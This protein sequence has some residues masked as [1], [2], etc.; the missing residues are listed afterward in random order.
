MR[1]TRTA[2]GALIVALFLT[3]GAS[4]A[5]AQYDP[6]EGPLD[7]SG[8]ATPGGSINISG[9]CYAPNADIEISVGGTVVKTVKADA[10]GRFSTSVTIPANASGS[11]VIKATGLTTDGATCV[12]STTVTVSAAGTTARSTTSGGTRLPVTG[13]EVTPGFV[14]TAVVLLAVGAA[15]VLIAR[16]RRTT[17][18]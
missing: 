9:A 15:M 4:A 3:L 1:S 8:T 13:T 10:D 18:A 12:L 14:I 7:T 2:I 6:D 5:H 16:R 11:V 17:S